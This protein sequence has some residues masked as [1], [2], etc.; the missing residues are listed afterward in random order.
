MGQRG[1]KQGS[2]GVKSKA[3][4]LSIATDE[5]ATNGFHE[6]KIS[7]IVKKAGVTQ[8]T[9][10]LY[11]HSKEAIFQELVSHFR[12]KLTDLTKESRLESGLDVNTLPGRIAVGL[13]A[14]FH[15]LN[16]DHQLTKIGFFI[17]TEADDIKSQIADLI[18]SNL[19]SEQKDGYFRK[20]IDMRIVADGLVGVIERLTVTSLFKGLKKPDELA[21]E[22][23]DLFLYGLQNQ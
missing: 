18:A 20:D 1:R 4:L 16:E 3:K 6:T 9:F 12:T 10:Y 15:F 23:V 7:N 21:R 14:I 17:S 22:I 8:P 2:I 5:F 11:F 19:V 13:S